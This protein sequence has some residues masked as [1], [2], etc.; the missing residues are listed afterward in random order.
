M[1]DII[2]RFLKEDEEDV[3]T[4]KYLTFIIDKQTY[5]VEI[6]NVKEI[7][8]I[9]ILLQCLI[10]LILLKELLMLG[11]LLFLLLT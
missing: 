7:I 3:T 8:S 4:E 11:A 5:A 2:N 10:F 1:S 6:S 9:Q